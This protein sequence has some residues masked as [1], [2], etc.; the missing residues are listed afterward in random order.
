MLTSLKR[1]IQYSYKTF[2][3]FKNGIK[4]NLGGYK[5]VKGIHYK[6]RKIQ[7]RRIGR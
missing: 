4:S 6:F 5:N 7:R 3:T 2:K 1:V